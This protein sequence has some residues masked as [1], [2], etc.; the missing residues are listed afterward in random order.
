MADDY[1]QCHCLALCQ[2][3]IISTFERAEW[4]AAPSA[5]LWSQG[6]GIFAS[7]NSYPCSVLFFF[8]VCEVVVPDFFPRTWPK[9][10]KAEED[11][12]VYSGSYG[13]FLFLGSRDYTMALLN[14]SIRGHS[15]L[16]FWFSTNDVGLTAS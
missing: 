9:C 4:P 5:G 2:G 3:R 14:S 10:T 16:V 12:V 11:M 15:T 13:C 6:G 8:V 7:F 1:R